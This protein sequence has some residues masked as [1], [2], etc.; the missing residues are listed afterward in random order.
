M[1]VPGLAPG[2]PRHDAIIMDGN[3]RWATERGQPRSAGPRQGVEGDRCAH[4]ADQLRMEALGLQASA[5]A[6]LPPAPACDARAQAPAISSQ[7]WL[8]CAP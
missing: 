3:G 6:G 5:G 1:T 7:A 2:V 4:G 8:A